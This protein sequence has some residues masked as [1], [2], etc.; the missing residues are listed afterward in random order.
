MS[1]GISRAKGNILVAVSCFRLMRIAQSTMA[2]L[3]EMLKREETD[4]LFLRIVSDTVQI[5]SVTSSSVQPPLFCPGELVPSNS[6][7]H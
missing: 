1:D 6:E 2:E 4:Y 5:R 7:P 3:V